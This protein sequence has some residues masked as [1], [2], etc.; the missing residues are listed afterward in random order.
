M[1]DTALL[2]LNFRKFADTLNFLQSVMTHEVSDADVIIL[3]NGSQNES[4]QEICNWLGTNFPGEVANTT[5]SPVSF[6]DKRFEDAIELVYRK[7]RVSVFSSTKNFGFSGGNNALGLLAAGMGYEYLFFL[8]SDIEFCDKFT[9][10]K[11]KACHADQPRAYLSGPTVINKN[12]TFDSP[13]KRDSYFGDLFAYPIVNYVRRKL[14]LPIIQFD[15]D[16]LSKPTGAPVYKISGAALF[17]PTR[18]FLEIGMFD[19]NVWLSCEEAILA[20]KIVRQGALT[21][22]LPTT[23]MLHIK[24]S[25]PRDKNRRSDILRNHFKQRN[26]FYRA[27]KNYG[28]GRLAFLKAGQT[29]RIWLASF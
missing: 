4:I 10:R 2:V 7:G 21:V 27:Y 29:L 16:A 28:A 13:Y 26:Y 17:F 19:E 18:R 12:G 1:N 23:V 6:E 15:L 11:L 25:A 22:F 3:D 24:A 9:V 20:E 8:N 5:A 14:G